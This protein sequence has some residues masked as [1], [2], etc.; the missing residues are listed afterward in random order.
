MDQLLLLGVGSVNSESEAYM[1]W[2]AKKHDIPTVHIV[3]N[4]DNLSTKGYRGVSIERLLVWGPNMREDAIKLQGIQPKRITEIG[5]IR[6]NT[7]VKSPM[8]GKAAFF[9]SI[10]LDPKKKTILFAGFIFE[11]HYFEMLEVHR[12]L[13]RENANTQMILRVYP[14]K[15][16]MKSI[17]IEPLLK[18]VDTMK[19]VYVS[20]AD[21]H[22]KHGERGKEV[23][24]IDEDELWPSLK[25]SDIIIQF[26]STIALEACIFDKPVLNIYYP[27]ISEYYERP[28]KYRN[29][30]LHFH[31]R[32]LSSL[33]AVQTV[34]DRIELIEMI[35]S[36][37][38]FPEKGFS[39]RKMTVEKECGSLDGRAC[40]RLV[41]SCYEEWSKKNVHHGLSS[42]RDAISS[43]N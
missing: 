26:Y 9:N 29:Y 35:R 22:Y 23:M 20:L 25:W 39:E 38:D 27:D 19:D 6:Y 2:W 36:A 18:Y 30:S 17:Y 33:G 4:Y 7:A 8:P 16:L 42:W 40:D 5:S 21:P 24:Q 31:H 1:S 37:F 15:K 41:Q 32:R 3:G 28:P 14:N 12:Q 43:K 13:L 11:S 10:G 34:R